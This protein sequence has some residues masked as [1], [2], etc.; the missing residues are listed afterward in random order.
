MHEQGIYKSCPRR[1]ARGE[2][3]GLTPESANGILVDAELRSRQISR[4][5]VRAAC[6]L[7]YLL[8]VWRPTSAGPDVALSV[9][10][11]L[12]QL[13]EMMSSV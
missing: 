10:S 1:Q 12:A 3:Y 8:A 13:L 2:T 7:N 4:N 6:D 5:D 11:A 9:S